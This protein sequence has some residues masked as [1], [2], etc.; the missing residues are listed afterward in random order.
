MLAK[1]LGEQGTLQVEVVADH[2]AAR[3]RANEFLKASDAPAAVI[4]GGGSGTLRA[5]IEG[6][7]EGRVA[8]E[9]PGRERVRVGAL[10]MGSGNPL[11]RQF[12]IPQD[13]E[14]GLRGVI[15]NLRAGRTA[16]CCAVRLVCPTAGARCI[17]PPPWA[18][19]DSSAARQEISC[20]CT[21]C[22]RRRARL[23]SGFWVSRG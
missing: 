22:C 7:C 9:L 15:E 21:A 12:G 1:L 13:P 19:L 3:A 14:A 23:R 20:A 16:G 5:V 11:A 2:P 18:A 6:L 17:T 4:V 10:R 8:G